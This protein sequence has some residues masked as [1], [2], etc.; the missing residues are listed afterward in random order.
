MA[1]SVIVPKEVL[2]QEWYK[3]PVISRLYFHFLFE[4]SYAD[5]TN[6]RIQL[7]RGQLITSWDKLKAELNISIQKLRTALNEMEKNGMIEREVVNNQ[8]VI[9]IKNYEEFQSYS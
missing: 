5:L 7:K 4:A 2:Y 6:S 9:T 3:S 8:S 1:G